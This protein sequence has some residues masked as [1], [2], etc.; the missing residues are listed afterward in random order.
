MI[1][2]KF[3]ENCCVFGQ[4]IVIAI[5]IALSYAT[6]IAEDETMRKDLQSAMEQIES[7]RAELN[8]M[9]ESSAWQYRAEL[10]E[11][12]EQIPAAA[13]G[14]GG[15]LILPAGW[16][17]KPYGYVKFDYIYDDS[18]SGGG[19][20]GF[21]HPENKSNRSD[22]RTSLTA[23]QTRLGMVI[24]AP[25]VGDAKVRAIFE[26]DFWTGS[27]N[28]GTLRMRKA[29][30]QVEGA[31]WM[32]EFGQDWEIIS[33][34]LPDTLNFDYGA[35]SGNTGFR[36][37]QISFAKWWDCPDSDGRLKAQVALEREMPFDGDELGLEDGQDAEWA[38]VLGRVSL[39]APMCEKK[40][41]VGLSGHVGEEEID[42]TKDPITGVI[43]AED[44]ADDEVNTWSVNA[45]MV[46]PLTDWAWLMGEFFWGENLDS[47]TGTLAGVNT[48]TGD[49]IEVLGGWASLTV[50]PCDQ[51]KF[52]VGL[53]VVD[54]IDGDLNENSAN[55][56]QRMSMNHYYFSNARYFFCKYLWTGL[57]VS[58]YQTNYKGSDDGDNFRIQHSWAL[59][60]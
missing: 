60:F 25:N 24:S 37:P 2:A 36:Y 50:V 53:G 4:L 58:Y 35:F 7:L 49:E 19:V 14:G 11:T 57:E 47:H 23:K 13:E 33:P 43:A 42:W 55:D 34:L 31:D 48:T 8:T 22:A 15:S 30:G 1:S 3:S 21:A 41:E 51:W 17:I 29:L 20:C 46:L 28:S 18:R 6:A 32:L 59:N 39:S 45:D 9:K 26:T 52:N 10:A 16:S 5:A 40:F 44:G 27:E 38:S 54:P 56:A 12:L